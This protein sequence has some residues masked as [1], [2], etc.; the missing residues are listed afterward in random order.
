MTEGRT[1]PTEGGQRGDLEDRLGV[2]SRT[3]SLPYCLSMLT[4]RT[5]M[6]SMPMPMGMGTRVGVVR[7]IG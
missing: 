1:Q 7:A 5:N 6:M 4:S 2:D 3:A